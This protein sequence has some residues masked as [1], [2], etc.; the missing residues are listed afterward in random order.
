MFILLNDSCSFTVPSL[1]WSILL[2]WVKQVCLQYRHATCCSDPAHWRSCGHWVSPHV[3]HTIQALVIICLSI[4]L[5]CSSNWRICFLSLLFAVVLPPCLSVCLCYSI[6]L[7]DAQYFLCDRTLVG[8]I[9]ALSKF[10]LGTFDFVFLS[11]LTNCRPWFY[12][13]DID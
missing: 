8:F 10:V 4:L 3:L 2:L 1:I 12:C 9:L 7:L 6:P 13:T 5:C 11:L